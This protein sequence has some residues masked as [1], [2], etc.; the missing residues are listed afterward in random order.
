ML[1]TSRTSLLCSVLAGSVI[2]LTTLLVRAQEPPNQQA[3]ERRLINVR[4]LTFGGQNAEAYF[5]S[6]A[7]K[8]IFQ[9]TRPPY[10]CDQIFSMNIDGSDVKLLN[11]GKG[12][13]TC[14]FF[15]LDGKR[16][17]YASTHLTVPR[18]RRSRIAARAMSGRFI[19][20]TKSFVPISTVRG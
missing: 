2:A 1:S 19:Q 5:S 8:I 6:D 9:S 12:R 20:V 18:V 16:I 10:P 13:T 14:G 7:T 15:F 17:I 4:Q 3:Q 11:S